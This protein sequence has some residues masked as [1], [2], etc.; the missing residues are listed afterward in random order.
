MLYYSNAIVKL[1]FQIPNRRIHRQGGVFHGPALDLNKLTSAWCALVFRFHPAI[2]RV[3]GMP[4]LAGDGIKVAKAGKK[5]KV[6][7]LLKETGQLQ[8]ALSP[9][10]GEKDVTLRFRTADLLWRPAGILVRFV[11]VLHPHRGAILLMSTD[12]TLSPLDIIRVYGLR[13]KIEV[14]FKQAIRV[15]GAPMHITSGSPP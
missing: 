5:I 8:E 7:A 13:F 4:V 14:S 6:A 10:Y 15:I 2:L 12:R 11:A 1:A 9:V 3:N